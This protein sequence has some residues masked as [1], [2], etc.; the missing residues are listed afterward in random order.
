M[1][2][3]GAV[4]RNVGLHQLA[5]SPEA[6]PWQ[7]FEAATW[8]VYGWQFT[9][10]EYPFLCGMQAR[11]RLQNKTEYDGDYLFTAAP[12]SDGFSSDPGQSKEFYFLSLPAVGRFTAQPTNHVLIKDKSF[13]TLA[14]P[15][16][17]H[18]QRV[19]FSAE[20]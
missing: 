5:L 15:D 13:V 3:C 19:W 2:E 7:P 6:A 20:T 10:L 12:L 11:V 1:L 18:R 16:F 14:W 17:L 4:Y 9:T 8:D